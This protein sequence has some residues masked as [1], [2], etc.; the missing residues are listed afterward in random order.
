MG[1]LSITIDTP[2]GPVTLPFMQ[3]TAIGK[4]VRQLRAEGKEATWHRNECGC[5]FTVHEDGV[6]H[7]YEGWVIGQDGGVD[8]VVEDHYGHIKGARIG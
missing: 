2:S 7:V 1:D 3:V 8:Y 4:V 5:C 6:A